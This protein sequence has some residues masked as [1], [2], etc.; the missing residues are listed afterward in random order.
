[1]KT[2]VMGILNTTPDS[3]FD[4]GRFF[5]PNFAIEH[6]IKMAEFGADIIDIGGESTRPGAEKVDEMDELKRVIPILAELKSRLSIP[7]SIDTMK[8]SVAR[9]AISAGATLINDVSGFSSPEMRTLA[10]RSQVDICV[11]HMQGTPDVMQKNP[12]YE[13]GVIPYLIKWF[14]ERIALLLRD[15]TNY[16]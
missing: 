12:Y 3:F 2:K 8:P 7:L 9:A 13:E 14:D 6:A 1:M 11:M 16:N 4:K 10:A 5:D 15:G